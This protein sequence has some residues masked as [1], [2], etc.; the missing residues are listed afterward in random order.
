M[1]S[2]RNALIA[3]ALTCSAHG[4]TAMPVPSAAHFGANQRLSVWMPVRLCNG[5]SKHT[6]T[7]CCGTTPPAWCGERPAAS[8]ADV[9][10]GYRDGA[11]DRL[12]GRSDGGVMFILGDPMFYACMITCIT[13]IYLMAL[14]GSGRDHGVE[15]PV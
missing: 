12:V 1:R 3:I 7:L 6:R 5:I 14:A 2:V 11:P 9:R 15:D 13:V 4:A 8:E 10:G